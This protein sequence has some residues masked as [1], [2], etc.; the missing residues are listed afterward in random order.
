MEVEAVQTPALKNT[1]RS[2]FSMVAVGTR[3]FCFGGRDAKNRVMDDLAV[4]DA[5]K[6]VWA[7]LSNIPGSQPCRRSSQT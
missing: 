4:F 5:A 2:F 6:N 7:V 3:C 1:A